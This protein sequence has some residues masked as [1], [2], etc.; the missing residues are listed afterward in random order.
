MYKFYKCYLFR[1]LFGKITIRW[2]MCSVIKGKMQASF[3]DRTMENVFEKLYTILQL[4]AITM[5]LLNGQYIFQLSDVY[6]ICMY[7]KKNKRIKYSASVEKSIAFD[8]AIVFPK[9]LLCCVCVCYIYRW[10]SESIAIHLPVSI[11]FSSVV[12]IM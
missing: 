2:F 9:Y 5:R 6:F 10:T 11:I 1:A 8:W 7:A 3:V 12:S 4:Q